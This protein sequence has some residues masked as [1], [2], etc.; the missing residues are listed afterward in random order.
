MSD[1]YFLEFGS[2]CIP[3][4]K[5]CSVWLLSFLEE[6]FSSSAVFSLLDFLDTVSLDV[7]LIDLAGVARTPILFLTIWRA[8]DCSLVCLKFVLIFSF[9]TLTT[10]LT[11]LLSLVMGLI[12][13]FGVN[14]LT[15]LLTSGNFLSFS[16][17]SFRSICVG[18]FSLVPLLFMAF[19]AESIC[20][21]L[22][23]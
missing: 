2:C 9:T 23:G 1:S 3:L 20:T 6:V 12:E 11:S 4:F 22:R 16:D 19:L 17:F 14:F 15:S 10:L 18:T 8:T 21:F 5:Y 7:D 13:L